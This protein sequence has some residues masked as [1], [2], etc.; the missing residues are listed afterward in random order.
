MTG[1][2]WNVKKCNGDWHL[3]HSLYLWYTEK[4]LTFFS[5]A[6]IDL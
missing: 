6:D 2:P 1:G 4:L 5:Y 3:I